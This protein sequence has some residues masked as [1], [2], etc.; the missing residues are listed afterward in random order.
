M[1]WSIRLRRR[2]CA[3]GVS[4][5]TT[6]TVPSGLRMNPAYLPLSR[7]DWSDLT[8]SFLTHLPNPTNV[9]END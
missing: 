6:I 8:S 7:S 5:E 9:R 3:G 4:S 2:D 1:R